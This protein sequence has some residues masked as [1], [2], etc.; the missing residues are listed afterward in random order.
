M[1]WQTLNSLGTTSTFSSLS[2]NS[3]NYA[4][5]SNYHDSAN[6]IYNGNA[7]GACKLYYD[8]FPGKASIKQLNK[9]TCVTQVSS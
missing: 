4:R 7:S 8:A 3:D 2:S 6:L 5:G 9:G 1:T